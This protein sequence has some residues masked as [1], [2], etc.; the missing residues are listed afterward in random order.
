MAT[1]TVKPSV[2]VGEEVIHLSALDQQ[3]QRHYAKPL[4]FFELDHEGPNDPVLEHL[5]KS[6]SVALSEAPDFASTVAP[7]PGS[8]RKE[9]QLQLNP[10]SG[11]SWRVFDHTA[12]VNKGAWSYGSFQELAAKH[13][14]LSD[15][16][17]ELLVD[18]TLVDIPEDVQELPALSIQL[19]L[20]KGG[21]ILAICWHHTVSDARGFNVLLNSW[22]RHTKESMLRGEPDDA[23]IPA[24]EARD[25]WRLDHGAANATI[26]QIPE[27]VVDANARSPR[28]AASLHLLD[29]E[30][31]LGAP[32][33]ISTWYLSSESLQSLRDSLGA[34][35][36]SGA[37]TP[38]E[39]VSALFW[40]HISRARGL[41]DRSEE[42]ATSLFT[43]R[44]E[45]RARLLPP[46]SG[47]YIGNIC[48]P[49]AHARLPLSELC[50]PATGTSL[51]KV[52]SA[53]RAAT[54]AVDDAA[55]RT[56][57]GLINTL[58][59]VT[60]LTWNYNGFP[61]PDFGVT[62]VSGLDICRTDW[63]PSL[64]APVCLRLAYREGGLLYLFPIDPQ[65]GLEV[66]ALCEP[67]AL[68]KLKADEGLAK[69]A[70]FRG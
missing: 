57:I 49:N 10:K 18:S 64:G 70:T 30:D 14:S 56:Y 33:Q 47:D 66:Q 46:L 5:K 41:L 39:A 26:A 55:V 62:D 44:L 20:I 50:S 23:I 8:T 6:L 36:N 54:E 27:Y 45:F 35:G 13:F 32:F 59:A 31:P 2:P 58:P 63:G 7:L 40:K 34:D 60:D 12:E 61:G 52:A 51:A 9:L 24:E 37:F 42:G 43:T 29:R 38:V 22:A 11:A 65:G 1:T 48:E 21:I 68:E 15:V 69:F 17:T 16:P 25:R 67:D 3:A 28:S 19:N 4:L 53:I